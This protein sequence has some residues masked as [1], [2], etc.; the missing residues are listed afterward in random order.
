MQSFLLFRLA[1]IH[2]KKRHFFGGILDTRALYKSINAH[3]LPVC[4]NFGVSR[5]LL[6]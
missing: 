2:C 3:M 6:L 5:S 4:S 1:P